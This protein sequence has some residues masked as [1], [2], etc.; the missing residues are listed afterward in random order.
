M[1]I[2]RRELLRLAALGALG[3]SVPGLSGCARLLEWSEAQRQAPVRREFGREPAATQ[4]TGTA[5]TTGSAPTPA[6]PDLGGSS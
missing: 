3:A 6:P 5:E 4:A 1:L 2:D